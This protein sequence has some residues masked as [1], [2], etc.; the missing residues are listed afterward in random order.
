LLCLVQRGCPLLAGVV[1][2]SLLSKNAIGDFEIAMRWAS[3][4]GCIAD[5]INL[6]HC[7]DLQIGQRSGLGNGL[8]GRH[9]NQRCHCM[10][11][12]VRSVGIISQ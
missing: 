8:T 12:G 10:Y 4:S 1:L 2:S 7:A 9:A 5:T 6:L 3:V 11:D